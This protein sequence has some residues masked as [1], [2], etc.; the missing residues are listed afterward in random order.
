MNNMAL[1]KTVKKRKIINVRIKKYDLREMLEFIEK[2][3]KPRPDLD[4][5]KWIE[6]NGL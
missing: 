4:V 3:V 6:K 2:N 1:G 5:V